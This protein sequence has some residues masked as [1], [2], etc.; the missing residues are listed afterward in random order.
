MKSKGADNMKKGINV[1]SFSKKYKA[2]EYIDLSKAYGFQGL[3]LALDEEGEISLNSKEEELLHIKKYAEEMNI[4]LPSV[5]SGLYWKYSLTSEDNSTREKAKDIVKKQLEVAATLGANTILVVPGAVGV[6]FIPNFKAVNYEVAYNTS[7][8][9]FKELKQYA[10]QYKVNIGLENVWNKFLLSPLEMKNFIDEIDSP[11]VGAYVDVGN[12]VYTGYPEH[13]ISI[14]NKRIKKIHVKDFKRAVGN[15]NGFVD[16]FGGDVNY[17]EVI[18]AL[19]EIG[20][21]DYLTAEMSP[22]K[23]NENGI[24]LSTS[25]ALDKMMSF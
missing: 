25:Y 1:W 12:L 17:P 7:L 19:R 23:Y 5:A 16:L 3:E 15:I 10:E 18:Q 2:K 20:Y 4:E 8:E 9:S 22:Y 21:D 13:W 6:D 14:L 24:L 11:Y